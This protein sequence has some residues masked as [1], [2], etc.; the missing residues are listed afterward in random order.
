MI[1][2]QPYYDLFSK[3]NFGQTIDNET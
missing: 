1:S 3:S 2:L